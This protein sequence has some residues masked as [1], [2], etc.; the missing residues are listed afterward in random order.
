MSKRLFISKNSSETVQL[1]AFLNSKNIGLI[2]HSFLHFEG[3]EFELESTYDIVFFT[4]P[5]SVIFFK[6]IYDVPK[7]VK[8]ACTGSKTAELLK[9]LG[10]TVDFKGEKSGDI[11]SVAD[12]FEKWAEGRMVLFPISDLSLR[13][14]S[15]NLSPESVIEV[16]VYKTIIQGIKV[17]PSDYYVFTSPS[18]VQ[19]FL[20][21]N[22]IPTEGKI[23]AWGTSTEE[24]LVAN[25]FKIDTTLIESSIDELIIVLN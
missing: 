11:Q 7:S 16:E 4:S 20:M 21:E 13:T 18:N 5:R 23:I 25:G 12:S 22:Q 19:G 14:I 24:A 2:S 15:S 10:Y 3:I 6:A 9:A 17:A 8:I 1:G